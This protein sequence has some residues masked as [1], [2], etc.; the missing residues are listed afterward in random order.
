MLQKLGQ[1]LE[2]GAGGLFSGAGARFRLPQ[3]GEAGFC[4]GELALELD[5]SRLHVGARGERLLQ[6]KQ[7]GPQF[8][9]ALGELVGGFVLRGGRGDRGGGL[10]RG[11]GGGHGACSCWSGV[12]GASA[13]P[14]GVPMAAA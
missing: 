2:R 8:A 12:W 1:G 13:T 11:G 14:C 6:G 10:S 5:D 9:D 4:G 7:L 3:L